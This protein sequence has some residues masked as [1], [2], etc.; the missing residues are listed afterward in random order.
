MIYLILVSLLWAFS[1]G[2][3]KHSLS[4]VN[5]S[6]TAFLRLGISTIVF[7]PFLKLKG[8]SNKHKFRFMLT[9]GVQ[10]GIMYV[11]YISSFEYLQAYEVAVLTIFTPLY[12][13]F[14][15]NL[16]QK[17]FSPE[18]FFASLLA[19]IGAGVIIYRSISWENA[20]LGFFLMQIA[21]MSFAFGQ[22][23]YKKIM[24]EVELKDAEVFALLYFGSAIVSFLF[25]APYFNMQLIFS[26]TSKEISAIVYLGAVASGIGFFLWNY[27]ARKVNDGTL[28]VF[29]NLKIP[30]SIGVSILFFGEVANL[31]RLVIGSVILGVA[32]YLCEKQK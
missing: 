30:F 14:F 9:G 6:L 1:F 27:G 20:L 10:Y 23:F 17:K 13:I 12:V 8:L 28:A 25:L 18:F 26:L 29:N 22:V 4:G 5:P 21:N 19:I 3:I 16:F 11:A 31:P 24:A 7:S 15:S 32:L 2:I